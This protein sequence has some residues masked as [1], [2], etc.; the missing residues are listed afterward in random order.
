MVSGST[1]FFFDF[2]IDSIGADR[3]GLARLGVNRLAVLAAHLL[4][5]HPFSVDVLIGLVR[6]HALGEQAAERL[7]DGDV[8]GL[9]HGAGEEARI[10]E[11]QNRVLDAADILI[12]RQPVAGR[13]G[14]GRL[15]RFRRA[16]AREVPRRVRRTCPWY[17]SRASPCR[18]RCGQV[19]CFQ[20]GWWSSGL[21][22]LVE[23]HIVGKLHRQILLRHRHDAAG[24]AMDHR[25]RA[26]PIALPRDAPV[27]QAILDLPLADRLALHALSWRDDRRS[28]SLAASTLSPSRKPEL[29]IT[30]SPV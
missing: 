26:A 14:V 1:T 10:E 21:P 30:P 11:M 15:A 20:V 9:V 23:A 19:T 24:R 25:D 18:R 8:P 17:R 4:G 29:I 28:S 3:D 7:V 13:I 27:A 22:G 12:D 16:E 6:D 5:Q 2:D